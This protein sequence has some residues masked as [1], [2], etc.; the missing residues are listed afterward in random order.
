MNNT[1]LQLVERL[2]RIDEVKRLTGL[3]TASIYRRVAAH[4]F[5]APVRLGASARAWALSEVQ[6]WITSR[7]AQRVSAEPHASQGDWIDAAQP[8]L[9]AATMG[10]VDSRS[11]FRPD[12]PHSAG[13]RRAPP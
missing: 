3:S 7:M 12:A 2:I 4:D 13:K 9:D 5:P 11:A 10:G 1:E 6:A 8:C